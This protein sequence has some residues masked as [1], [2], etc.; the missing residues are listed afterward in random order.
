MKT[1]TFSILIIV[2][3]LLSEL[4]VAFITHSFRNLPILHATNYESVDKLSVSRMKMNERLHKVIA[5]C[6]VLSRRKAEELIVDGAVTVNGKIIKEL[7]TKI[8]PT[9]DSVLVNG[10]K[11][12]L[13]E[14]NELT[15]MI[16]NK[17]KGVLTTTSDQKDR[18]TIWDLVPKAKSLHLLPVGRLERKAC[19]L[20]LMTND[21]SWIHPLT[22]P[23]Y[24]VKKGFQVVI[25]GIPDLQDIEDMKSGL[26]FPDEK[27]KC[28]P[29]AVTVLDVDRKHKLTALDIQI[30]EVRADHIGRMMD[31][32][33]FE[34]QRIKRTDFGAIRLSKIP[35]GHARHL[36]PTEVLKLKNSCRLRSATEHLTH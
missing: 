13:L 35:L 24:A 3:F 15:W 23:S 5:R 6:G 8:N 7:G 9:I 34:I 17:P 31:H 27:T 32:F 20:V 2:L 25:K 18:Q 19:G 10:K 22:H 21:I 33:G 1:I 11:I 4:R 28:L 36:T 14:S 29:C 26:H 30:Y 16:L 12:K